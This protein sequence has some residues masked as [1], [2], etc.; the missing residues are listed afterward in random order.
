M[1]PYRFIL[2]YVVPILIVLGMVGYIGY[3]ELRIKHLKTEIEVIT[4]HRDNL[5]VKLKES[6]SY[7][8]ML[9]KEI[10]D[11]SNKI[12]KMAQDAIRYKTE[13]ESW[14]NSKAKYKEEILKIMNQKT[15]T[16]QD[17]RNKVLDMGRIKYEDL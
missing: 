4:V 5:E 1:I 13:Y 12:N 17:L 2:K 8:T 14:L 10:T 6:I 9:N 3:L 15:N 16:D 7:S 11:L